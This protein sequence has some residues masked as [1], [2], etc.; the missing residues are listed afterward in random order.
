ME[1]D[2][3]PTRAADGKTENASTNVVA[4][5]RREQGH[6]HVPEP[7]PRAGTERRGG[8]LEARVDPGQVAGRQ[9]EREREARIV[10]ENRTTQ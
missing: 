7:L 6:R 9:Q 10:S 2:G 4:S 8:P 5:P 1:H 3:C